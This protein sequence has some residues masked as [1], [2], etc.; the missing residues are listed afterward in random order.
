M[1]KITV[2]AAGALPEV[3]GQLIHIDT[4]GEHTISKKV[5]I[6]FT[7]FLISHVD[8]LHTDHSNPHI[9]PHHPSPPAL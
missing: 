1:G 6:Y 9:H 4:G 7:L 3:S 2:P 8:A 5:L